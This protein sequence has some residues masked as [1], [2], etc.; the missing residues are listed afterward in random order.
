MRLTDNQLRAIK[1]LYGDNCTKLF[2][3]HDALKKVRKGQYAIFDKD[4]SVL[5]GA[6]ELYE[7]LCGDKMRQTLEDLSDAELDRIIAMCK[8]IKRSR[9]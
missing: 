2:A 9:K 7:L 8:E 3:V 1:T 6:D 4:D 5:Y